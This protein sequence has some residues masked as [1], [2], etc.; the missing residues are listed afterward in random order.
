MKTPVVHINAYI[1]AK[2]YRCG[3][4]H[5]SSPLFYFLHPDKRL[6]QLAIYLIADFFRNGV[7]KL[8]NQ[9]IS[10]GWRKSIHFLFVDAV[11]DTAKQ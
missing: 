7:T 8:L 11:I 3:V 5:R 10:T 6:F 4:G 2:G 9:F 1:S